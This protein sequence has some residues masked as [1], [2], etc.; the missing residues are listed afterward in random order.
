MQKLLS[1]SCAA[2]F[3]MLQTQQPNANA[4]KLAAVSQIAAQ[5][6]YSSMDDMY[7]DAAS[8]AQASIEK[9]Y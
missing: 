4:A 8:E 1:T 6:M 3:C 5:D 7:N 2:M 9:E